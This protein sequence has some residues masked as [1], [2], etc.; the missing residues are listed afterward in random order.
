MECGV[1]STTPISSL[2]QALMSEGFGIIGRINGERYW[3]RDLAAFLEINPD[4]GTVP[5]EVAACFGMTP[6]QAQEMLPKRVGTA[7]DYGK[8]HPPIEQEGARW[9]D[10]ERDWEY[11]EVGTPQQRAAAIELICTNVVDPREYPK[12]AGPGDLTPWLGGEMAATIEAM[13]TEELLRTY[14]ALDVLSNRVADRLK[15][16]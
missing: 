3:P 16:D 8:G 10:W 1:V 13:S 4:N 2:A 11:R 6:E 7:A 9:Q 14:D 5:E 15:T 12:L